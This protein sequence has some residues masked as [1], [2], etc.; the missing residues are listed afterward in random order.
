LP[1]KV[2][3]ESKAKNASYEL[4]I[5]AVPFTP[6]CGGTW[7]FVWRIRKRPREY[8]KAS[9]TLRTRL[10]QGMG[11]SIEEIWDRSI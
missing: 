9:G 5:F 4:R 3:N 1:V 7:T 11:A 2:P 6:W 8:L 10:C